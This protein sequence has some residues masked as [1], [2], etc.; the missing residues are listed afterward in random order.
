MQNKMT[1]MHPCWLSIKKNLASGGK[2]N[3]HGISL[4]RAQPEPGQ[5]RSGPPHTLTHALRSNPLSAPYTRACPPQLG[6][7]MPA[8]GTS[9]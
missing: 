6:S 3:P 9:E 4:R 2:T 1:L 5:E 7:S 8:R